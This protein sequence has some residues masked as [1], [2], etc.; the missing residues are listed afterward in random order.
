MQ[1][2]SSAA[3][4]H[5][6]TVDGREFYIPTPTIGDV[7]TI[8]DLS[9]VDTVEQV[10]GMRSLLVSKAQPARLT[11]WERIVGRDPVGP[12]IDQLGLPQTRD[13]FG[14]WITSLSDVSLGESSG[15]AD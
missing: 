13:L 11:L 1:E 3:G 15:S 12:A 10:H 2:F 7:Q 8:N 5:S 6:F 14:A 4:R 9:K